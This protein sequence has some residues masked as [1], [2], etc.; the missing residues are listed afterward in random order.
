MKRAMGLFLIAAA[1]LTTGCAASVT[2]GHGYYRRGYYNG[3]RYDGDWDRHH[4][5]DWDRD[6]YRRY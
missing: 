4:R 3:Y 6:G 2:Y 5:R 1:L